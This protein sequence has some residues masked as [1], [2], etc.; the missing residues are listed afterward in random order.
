MLEVAAGVDNNIK[1]I[2]NKSGI[3]ID[4]VL[5]A[6]SALEEWM[7]YCL[8]ARS[9]YIPVP[10]SE[11]PEANDIEEAARVLTSAYR[12]NPT[13]GVIADISYSYDYQ[14]FLIKYSDDSK[15]RLDKTVKE[16]K[17][18]KEVAD[19]VTGNLSNDC[20][21]VI[22]LNDYFCEK[23]SYDHS[24][25]S[26]NVDMSS[27]SQ[28][29]IDAHTPYGILCNNYGVCESYSEAMALTGRLAGIDVI[30]EVGDLYGAGCHEWNRVKING[31]WCILDIT[32]NDNEEAPNALCN[33]TDDMADQILIPNYSAY[34][35]DASADTDQYEYYH[36]KDRYAD[37]V[38]EM[39]AK[40]K[41]QLDNGKIAVIRYDDSISEDDT[42]SVARELYQEGYDLKEA[43]SV[44][45]LFVLTM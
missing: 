36:Q 3:S 41:E 11:F 23:A 44:F 30:M 12:Q 5:F 27:L 37:S 43:Y 39:K 10:T 6:D 24:S 7:A 28:S 22:A 34:L 20:D 21:K 31:D 13:S 17:K 38:D 42:I 2:E 9:E 35:F 1:I 40:L 26:T 32:N 33:I 45:G 15:D 18:A 25:A 29:F 16:L 4:N 19:K 14:T 8:I